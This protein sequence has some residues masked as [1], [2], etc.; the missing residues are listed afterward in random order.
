MPPTADDETLVLFGRARP[1]AADELA[2]VVGDLDADFARRLDQLDGLAQ[3][4]GAL[5]LLTDLLARRSI[6]S[7]RYESLH[8]V[9]GLA[10]SPLPD[11]PTIPELLFAGESYTQPADLPRILSAQVSQAQRDLERAEAAVDQWAQTIGSD[12]HYAG[13]RAYHVQE[14]TRYERAMDLLAGGPGLIVSERDAAA[15]LLELRKE[16]RPQFAAWAQDICLAHLVTLVQSAREARARV[17]A[18]KQDGSQATALPAAA[19]AEAIKAAGGLRAVI[20]A[21]IAADILCNPGLSAEERA[22][23]AALGRAESS[24]EALEGAGLKSGPALE[25]RLATAAAA[26]KALAAHQAGAKRARRERA[27]RLVN[28]ALAGSENAREQLEGLAARAPIAFAPGFLGAIQAARIDRIVL[29]RL[30]A[31]LAA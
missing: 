28:D 19:C 18:L 2:A 26:K 17:A 5:P 25:D 30:A 23:T 3:L 6:Y 12:Q 1:D 27:E 13:M 24:A 22:L 7:G 15:R 10:F 21:T 4:R 11:P 8:R 29:T 31:E 20:E 9:L 14:K 16:P